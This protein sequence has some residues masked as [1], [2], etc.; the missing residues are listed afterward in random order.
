MPHDASGREIGD[1][2]ATV[3]ESLADS[4][5]S[6]EDAFEAAREYAAQLAAEGNGPVKARLRSD[7]AWTAA[8]LLA[9]LVYAPALP[10]WFNG[11]QLS[12]GGAQLMC[13]AVL[14]ALVVALPLYLPFLLRHV[15]ALT[16]I[17]L[18]GDTAGVLSALLAP[19]TVD[20]AL[21]ALQP[22]PVLIASI[23]VLVVLS[24]AGTIRNLREKP[25][26]V[27]GPLEDAP[28]NTPRDRWSSVLTQWLF[29]VL[30]GVL[31]GLTAAIH[32]LT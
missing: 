15:R 17:P 7:I 1:A 4:G 10:P 20:D 18:L 12:I 26:P 14:A 6:P 9:F 31:L 27:I 23:G 28:P 16:A 2:P 29:P 11:G 30:A 25:D 22:A 8:S 19:D 21:L 3:G 24:M 32:A 13:T 5:Q